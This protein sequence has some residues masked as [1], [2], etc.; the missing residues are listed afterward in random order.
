MVRKIT[1][2]FILLLWSVTAMAADGIYSGGEPVNSREWWG[3][4]PVVPPLDTAYLFARKNGDGAGTH[5]LIA[6]IFEQSATTSYTYPWN[7][8]A[9]TTLNN[10]SGEG[11]GIYSRLYNNANSWAAAIHSEPIAKGAGTNIAFNAETS[12]LTGF[13]GRMIAFNANAVDGY[14]G[15]NPHLWSESAYNVQSVAS[16]GFMDGLKIDA[17][18]T[19]TNAVH[20]KPTANVTFGVL[21]ESPLTKVALYSGPAATAV[22]TN[23][24]S[25]ICL[26]ATDQ[27]CLF[28]D[29]GNFRIQFVNGGRAIG[30]I[31][32]T[33]LTNVCM[34]C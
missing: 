31:K 3:A 4:Q 13:N 14:A 10:V 7:I 21:N 1:K 34:N 33:A 30:Y 19:V 26:E 29:A 2:L 9:Q 27:I 18:A 12:P 24:G 17:G 25:K 23:A 15:D 20:I 32:T 8:Y 28:Y 6:S 22:R 5:E 16:A 11:V